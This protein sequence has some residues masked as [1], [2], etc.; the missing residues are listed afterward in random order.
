MLVYVCCLSVVLCHRQI[1]FL[2]LFFLLFSVSERGVFILL[3]VPLDVADV[4]I[5]SYIDAWNL[6]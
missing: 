6:M 5:I 4:F 2:Y 3:S 1:L